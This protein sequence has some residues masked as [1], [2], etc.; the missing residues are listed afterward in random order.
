MPFARAYNYANGVV[1]SRRQGE[2]VVAAG[3]KPHIGY[4]HGNGI[5]RAA[6][7]NNLLGCGFNVVRRI[8]SKS[9]RLGFAGSLGE[10]SAG[11]FQNTVAHTEL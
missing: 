1:I 9:L 4:F 10:K 2:A 5:V 8:F 6:F 3:F 11:V 7:R